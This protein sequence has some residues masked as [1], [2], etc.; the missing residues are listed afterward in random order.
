MFDGLRAFGEEFGFLYE[1]FVIPILG[2][3]DSRFA[4]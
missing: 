4:A 1:K 2:E 3:K